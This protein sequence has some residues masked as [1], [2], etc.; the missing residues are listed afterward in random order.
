MDAEKM[1]SEMNE[2]RQKLKDD[3]LVIEMKDC[4]LRQLMEENDTLNNQLEKIEQETTAKI[5][6]SLLNIVSVM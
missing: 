5:E 4:N 3:E 1:N 6:V 2:I